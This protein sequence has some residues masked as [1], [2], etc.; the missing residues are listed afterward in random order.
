MKEVARVPV[1]DVAS[2]GNIA[3]YEV[4]SD[5][6]KKKLGEHF[7]RLRDINHVEH[8][9]LGKR[10]IVLERIEEEMQAYMLDRFVKIDYDTN[11]YV[12]YNS[13]PNEK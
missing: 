2:R 1:E 7:A 3:I 5:S 12:V 8:L 9:E 4:L 10:R 6:T 11:E 13:A